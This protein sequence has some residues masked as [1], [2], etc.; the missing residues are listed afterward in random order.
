MQWPRQQKSGLFRDPVVAISELLHVAVNVGNA[1]CDRSIGKVH[2]MS[3]LGRLRPP[4][5]GMHISGVGTKARSRQAFRLKGV[6]YQVFP[7]NGYEKPELPNYA[8]HF[9]AQS[10]ARRD[11]VFNKNNHLTN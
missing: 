11:P 3:A 1:G 10:A 5:L 6:E 8:A 9:A 4:D 2:R 7:A